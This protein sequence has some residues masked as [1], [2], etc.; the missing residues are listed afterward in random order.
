[1]PALKILAGGLGVGW[2]R[3]E[4]VEGDSKVTQL[5][6]PGRGSSGD[7]EHQEFNLGCLQLLQK[8]QK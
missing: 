7:G 4:R 1:M 6:G 3:K 8:S 5:G 2:K